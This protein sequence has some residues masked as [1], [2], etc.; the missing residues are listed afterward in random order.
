MTNDASSSYIRNVQ[1]QIL[2]FA[3]PMSIP[4]ARLSCRRVGGGASFAVT[5]GEPDPD[6]IQLGRTQMMVS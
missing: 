6:W 5:W 4:Q 2:T 1:F 3:F